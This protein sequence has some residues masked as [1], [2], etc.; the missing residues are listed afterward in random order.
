M[1][2]LPKQPVIV[3]GK[4]KGTVLPPGKLL[5]Q[6]PENWVRVVFKDAATGSCVSSFV[7]L[8]EVKERPQNA[9]D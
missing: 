7:P 5:P 3:F 1:A 6:N 4:H 8:T 9:N 2:F